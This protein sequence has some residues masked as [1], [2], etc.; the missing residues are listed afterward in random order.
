MLKQPQLI[1]SVLHISVPLIV[2][3]IMSVIEKAKLLQFR[4]VKKGGPERE[5]TKNTQGELVVFFSLTL[6]LL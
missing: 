2:S 5:K 6:F 4:G 1:S 3:P